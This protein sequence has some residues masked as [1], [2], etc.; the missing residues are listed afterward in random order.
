MRI[1]TALL[2]LVFLAWSGPATACL[3]LEWFA[4]SAWRVHKERQVDMA[5]VA[6]G[7]MLVVYSSEAGETWTIL[8][9]DPK[10]Q[11]VTPLANGTDWQDVEF[12]KPEIPS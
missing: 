12:K 11:C 2:A 6:T 7:D 5:L 8:L 4:S 9:V 10:T 1:I 3:K